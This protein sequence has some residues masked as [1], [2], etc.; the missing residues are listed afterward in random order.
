MAI[1]KNEIFQNI[2]STCEQK[3]V[4]GIE[5]KIWLFNRND[6]ESYSTSADAANEIT[7]IVLKSGKQGY[8]AEGLKKNLTAGFERVVSDTA[9]DTW[10]NTLTLLSYEF[11]KDAMRNVDELGDLV[12]IIERKGNKDVD[13]T[14]LVLGLT[15]GLYVSADSWSANDNSGA[16]SMTL[17]SLSDAG[18]P[19][20]A[21]V[22][23]LSGHTPAITTAAGIEAY[24]DDL[25]D[26][27]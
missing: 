24:L 17:S 6:I 7:E 12:A 26:V 15:N 25:C 20:S 2:Y 21:F 9:A 11:D 4:A 22:L 27:E 5:Q 1:C 3:V 16:R 18:E 13:G 10:T 8:V 23:T 19:Y 14:Y